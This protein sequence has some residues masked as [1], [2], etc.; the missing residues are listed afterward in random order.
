MKVLNEKMYAEDPYVRFVDGEV[1]LMTMPRRGFLLFKTTIAQLMLA[2]L[3][4]ILLCLYPV[5]V[6]AA[7]ETI[8]G[9]TWTYRLNGET[10][11]IYNN[12]RSAAVSPKPAG[13]L[14]MPATLGGKPVTIIGDGAFL[15]CEEL[16]NVKIPSSVTKIGED[17]FR[18]C[19]KLT[20]VLLPGS[21]TNIAEAAFFQ[22]EELKSVAI[23]NSV[24]SIG[25]SVF[26]ECSSLTNI[27]IPDSLTII[28]DYAF[29]ACFRLKNVLI[30]TSVTS[31][32]N[33][34][35]R[36][37]GLKRVAIPHSV[38]NIGEEAFENCDGLTGMLKIPDSVTTIRESTFR[39]CVRLTNIVIPDSV[40]KIGKGAFSGCIR[41]T[42]MPIPPSVTNIGDFA[43]G[44]CRGLTDKNGFVIL[45]SVLHCYA[46]TD[47]D[48]T[49]PQ[50]VTRI[51]AGA[52]WGNQG[53]K[54]VVIPSSVTSIGAN[55]FRDCRNLSTITIPSSVNSIG[56]L[57]FHHCEGLTSV[58]ILEGVKSIGIGAFDHCTRLRQVTIPESV[59]ILGDDVFHGCNSLENIKMPKRFKMPKICRRLEAKE[60]RVPAWG[61]DL[62]IP[63][64][65]GFGTL[66]DDNPVSK[67]LKLEADADTNNKT[68]GMWARTESGL[69]DDTQCASVKTAHAFYG[70]RASLSTFEAACESMRKEYEG[71]NQKFIPV[72]NKMAESISQKATN[73]AETNISMSIDD[74]QFLPPHTIGRD[75]ICF[76][77]IRKDRHDIGGEKS[78]SFSVTSGAMLW[79][80]GTVFSL[81]IND[82]IAENAADLESAISATRE[83]LSKWIIAVESVNGRSSLESEDAVAKSD[84]RC[85]T[86]DKR[87]NGTSD[88][89]Q[90]GVRSLN[91]GKNLV[92]AAI[93]AFCGLLFLLLKKKNIRSKYN[94]DGRGDCEDEDCEQPDD[95]DDYDDDDNQYYGRGG[96]R[97]NAGIPRRYYRRRRVR[98]IRHPIRLVL[99]MVLVALATCILIVV[100]AQKMGYVK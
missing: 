3:A 71:L 4:K 51:A 31:I 73:Q 49:I 98:K 100:V 84:P 41:L 47:V 48:V 68:I 69:W 23:P 74:V 20:S 30:P 10:A 24:R 27:E 15:D 75:R 88:K 97:W 9:Y 17:A 7:T 16:T 29:H 56:H 96:T 64:P 14:T 37:S 36:S 46:G 40:T 2:A 70:K 6:M 35:F 60:V 89:R 99:G 8:D 1:V 5:K 50:G 26:G 65:E 19:S 38:T 58:T 62:R 42:N 90:N 21:L 92:V 94:R 85:L 39:R 33:G 28:P 59:D 43:F 79:I 66:E 82:S 18:R 25:T 91:W 87:Q 86:S 67:F 54:T 95:D 80:R 12:S 76:T 22:C 81:S 11:E 52:F 77:M 61:K 13:N 63:A 93:G 53:L 45:R 78:V 34:A 83:K 57:A 72:A 44:N 55:A 32:G